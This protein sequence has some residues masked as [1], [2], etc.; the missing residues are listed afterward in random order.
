MGTKWTSWLGQELSRL[1]S[2]QVPNGCAEFVDRDAERMAR[3]LEL[4]RMRF[5]HHS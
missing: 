1:F 3:E 4:I 5:P 2:W